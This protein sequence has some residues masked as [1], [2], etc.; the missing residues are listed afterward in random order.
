MGWMWTEKKRFFR[1]SAIARSLWKISKNFLHKQC[2]ADISLH[3]GVFKFKKSSK[4]RASPRFFGEPRPKFHS[5]PIWGECG[6]CL[7]GWGECG[8]PAVLS[9]KK[10]RTFVKPFLG[11]LWKLFQ[12]WI[13]RTFF[14]NRIEL[15]R[16]F[17]SSFVNSRTFPESSERKISPQSPHLGWMW[18]TLVPLGW[19]WNSSYSCWD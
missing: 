11:R 8:I 7:F 4:L 1:R 3:A 15:L 16:R 14:Y 18:N 9:I 13:L 2:K 6:I 17:V 19:M 12:H 5:H 10:K